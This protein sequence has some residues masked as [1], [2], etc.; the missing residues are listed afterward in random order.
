MT[1][2][3]NLMEEYGAVNAMALDG[4][5]SSMLVTNDPETKEINIRTR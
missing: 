1:D 4:G 2:M 3:A 5:T